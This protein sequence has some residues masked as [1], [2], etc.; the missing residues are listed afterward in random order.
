MAR[1]VLDAKDFITEQGG[2]PEKIRE[3]QRR[4]YAPEAVVDEI[5][6]LWQDQRTSKAHDISLC[7][8]LI[9][10]QLAMPDLG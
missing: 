4:R 8:R 3:S 10:R 5:I 6:Q 9:L 7:L 2:N 1:M